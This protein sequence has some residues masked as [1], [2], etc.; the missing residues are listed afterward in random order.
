V[1]FRRNQI[2]WYDFS[3]RN[4]RIREST[5]SRSRT[6]PKEAELQRRRYLERGIHN[7][8]EVQQNRIRSLGDLAV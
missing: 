1:L 8:T 7:I 5:H 2:W 6:V 4:Q 3:F